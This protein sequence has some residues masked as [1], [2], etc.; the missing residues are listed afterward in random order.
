MTSLVEDLLLLARLDE[1]RDLESK[2]VDLSRLLIDA[3]GDAHAVSGDHEWNLELPPEPVVVPGD[4]ERLQQVVVNLL[5]N[6]WAHT[7]PGTRVEVSLAVTPGR[8]A[9]IDVHDDGPGIPDQ[10]KDVLFERF[11][12]GDNSR[13]RAQGSTGLGLAIVRA[14]VA[15]HG[16]TVT[17]Q[18]RPGDTLFRVLL[19]L[20]AAAS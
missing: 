9:A 13:S 11:A 12:R 3:V 1:G 20:A 4:A 2:P 6:S 10:V 18:S 14:I 5:T 16:G 19:P 8:L 15:G 7:P 17:V